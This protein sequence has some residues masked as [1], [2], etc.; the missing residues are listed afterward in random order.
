MEKKLVLLLIILLVFLQL[1]ATL[2]TI[3]TGNATQYSQPFNALLNYGWSKALYKSTELSA[4]GLTA[5]TAIYGLGFDLS[6]SANLY[7]L[8]NQRI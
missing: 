6:F 1:S 3:G 8:R 2:H 7:Q 5:G 4:A